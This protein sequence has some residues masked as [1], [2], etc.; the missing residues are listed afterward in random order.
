RCRRR[1]AARMALPECELARPARARRRRRHRRRQRDRRR[2]GRGDWR[3]RDGPQDVQRRRG[4]VGVRP[5]PARLVGRRSAVPS[6]RL[7]A[8]A[9]RAR[10]ARAAGRHDVHV[11]D[12]RH[13][14]RDRAGAQRRRGSRRADCRRGGRRP[15]GGR[16]GPRR[17]AHGPRR[18]GAPRG[19]R[20][21]VRQLRRADPALARRRRERADRRPPHLPDRRTPMSRIV[22]S[23]FV[24]LDGVMEDPGG[25]E[26]FDRGGW[27]FQFDRGTEGDKFKLD[28]LVNA[29]ALLLGRK[30]YEGFA[31][32]W[33]ERTDDAGFA[34]KMN[35][36]PKY[37]VSSTLREPTWSNTTVLSGDV[38]GSLARLKED[39]DGD[40][41]VA[42]SRQLVGAL[43][44]ND[45]VDEYRLMVFP[46]VLG[47]GK[48]LFPD[49]GGASALT[50][51][52]SRQAGEV[53]LL[54]LHRKES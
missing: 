29:S 19:R 48:K 25:A 30:T 54:T 23:E 28:E 8:H 44:A 4:P 5:E 38:A 7:R 3:V 46:V 10:A 2:V 18:A 9:P 49:T 13:R 40:I 20:A 16:G 32:A 45:L 17:R 31:A 24:T 33:P 37:V 15:A 35:S 27:A 43:V 47:A 21:A 26:P 50:V 42:G 39:V 53:V 34:D 51:V 52:E 22:V 36:M 12:R 11:R 6:A 1:T 41:L 14:G